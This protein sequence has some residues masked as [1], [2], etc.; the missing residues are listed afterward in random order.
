MAQ[1]AEIAKAPDEASAVA[2]AGAESGIAEQLAEIAEQTSRADAALQAAR[3]AEDLTSALSDAVAGYHRIMSRLRAP[4]NEAARQE[5]AILLELAVRRDAIS[6]LLGAL[7]AMSR[8]PQPVP[9][10]HP[11]GP[12]GA[13][14]AG[15]MMARLAPALQAE[16]SALKQTLTALGEA[17]ALRAR[18]ISD[19][20]AGLATLE[21]ARADLIASV[22]A[23]PERP[24]PDSE[25]ARMLHE[26]DTL[27]AL[28][29]ALAKAD[30]AA[31]EG[32]DSTMALTWPVEGVVANGY[33]EADAAG[34]RRP[35]ILVHVVPLALVKAP[36]DAIVRY[37]GPFL[38]YGYV[39]VLEP[40]ADV[41]VVLAGFSQLQV[42][43]GEAVE[44]GALL[45]L[46]GGR[47][48]AA[49]E[50]LRFPEMEAG[51]SSGE[52]LYI[53]IRHGQGPV[54]PQ[55]WFTLSNG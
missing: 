40:R 3:R 33:R 15:N 34:V 13:A 29:G 53:E 11:Q 27:S 2:E 12:L 24:A 54:D 21:A 44:R 28:A 35:G 22:A 36:A 30:G 50:F 32:D 7:Q 42:R 39:A 19:L 18:G 26:S 23:R 45:G 46:L 17:R 38:D 5:Q 49:E 9:A 31:A 52:T 41:L 10:L 16:V 48:L 37:A 6:R 8:T 47:A 55:P 4:I 25:A 43:T 14:R 20:E 51:G 1:D